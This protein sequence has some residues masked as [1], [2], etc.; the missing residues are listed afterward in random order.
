MLTIITQGV[1]SSNKLHVSVWKVRTWSIELH[2]VT[3]IE[4]DATPTNLLVMFKKW[5][6]K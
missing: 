3:E 1:V 5:Q 4:R 6:T 2:G